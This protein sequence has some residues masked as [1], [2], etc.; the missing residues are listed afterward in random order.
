M[1]LFGITVNFIIQKLESK[2]LESVC[3]K[4]R[5]KNPNQETGLMNSGPPEESN[6]AK[7]IVNY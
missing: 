5:Q 2:H 4:K 7:L 3:C 6:D 1:A